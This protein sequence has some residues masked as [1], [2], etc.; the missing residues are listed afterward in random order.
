MSSRT[1]NLNTYFDYYLILILSR[2]NQVDV[3]MPGVVHLVSKHSNGTLNL[4]K[5]QFQENSKYQSLV[6]VSHLSRVCG[7]RFLL[8]SVH[9]HPILPFLLTN[10]VNELNNNSLAEESSDHECGLLETF[11]RGIIIWG[12]EPVRPL[13][14]TG[15]I[16]ELARVDSSKP[17]SFE[18]IAWFPS[19]LPSS[20]LG[21]L[22]SSP[23]TLFAS[24]D[25][26]KITI[27]QA[28]F[29]ART[30]LHDLQ[31]QQTKN[32][33]PNGHPVYNKLISTVSAT[34]S[35]TTDIPY[36]NFNIVSIQSTARPGCIIELDH[37]A[38]S[39]HS[40]GSWL[41]ADLFHVYQEGLIRSASR[42][43]KQTRANKNLPYQP[44]SSASAISEQHVFNETF[45]VVLLEKSRRT[46]RLVQQI[47]MWQVNIKS[48]LFVSETSGDD[49]ESSISASASKNRL[50]I[51][52]QRVCNQEL[53]LP[54]GVHVVS[55]ETAA[56]DLA[57]SAMFSI[58]QVP[59][60]FATG[61][62]DG[63]VRF[64]SCSQKEDTSDDE[65]AQFEF[66]EWKMS[67]LSGSQVK[68][69]A[70][71]L[72]I[73]CSYN[74][75]F[76][77]AFRKA[78]SSV[79]DTKSTNNKT[80]ADYCVNIYECES[81]GG[82][83]WR[84]EDSICLNSIVL[85]ELDSGINLDYIFGD[86]KPIKP[87]RSMH[88]F[89]NMIFGGSGGSTYVGGTTSPPHSANIAA[90][91]SSGLFTPFNAA[92]D[93]KSTPAAPIP[94]EI[95]STAAKISIKRQITTL[96][97]IK[98]HN[99]RFK[100]KA[101]NLDWGSTENGSHI[102]TIGL[103]NRI[104]VYSCVMRA[105]STSSSS[106]NDGLIEWKQ[107]RTF[108]LDSAD[109]QQ[110]LPSHVKWVREGLL[111]IGLDTEMQVY[112]QW[113]SNVVKSIKNEVVDDTMKSVSQ[114]NSRKPSASIVTRKNASVLDLNKLSKMT[115]EKKPAGSRL[116]DDL[117]SERRESVM[118]EFERNN[119]LT[120]SKQF[121][122]SSIIQAP[123]KKFDHAELLEMMQDSGLFM[124]AKFAWPVLPQY[125]PRQLLELMN[126]GK[127]NRVKAI[128]MH[129][130]RCIIDFELKN[131]SKVNT[132]KKLKRKMSVSSE[133]EMPEEQVL[134]YLE[135]DTIPPLPL[136]ALF[137]SDNDD[138]KDQEEESA[139]SQDNTENKSSFDLLSGGGDSDELKLNSTAFDDDFE[140]DED[141]KAKILEKRAAK[142]KLEFKKTL[143]AS[144]QSLQNFNS[145]VCKLLIEY[146]TCVHL[147]GLTSIDQ[148]YLV[149]LADTVANVR[150]DNINMAGN[151]ND[152]FAKKDSSSNTTNQIVDNCGLKFLLALRSY[153]YLIRT[154][155]APN[156]AEL[157][158]VGLG[159]ANFAW[160]YHS[161]CEQELLA[162][163]SPSSGENESASVLTW[164]DLRQYGVG[165][166]LK[167]TTLLKQLI[168]KVA[169][170]AFQ[171]KNDPLD[172]ALFYLAMK[173][174]GVLWGLF[175]TVK[176]VK[177]SEFFKNDFAEAKWQTA[178][179]KNAF[180]LLGKQRFE[181]AAAFF[182]LAGRLKDAVE[183]CIRSLH[184]LQLALVIVRLY[185]TDYDKLS[186]YI[187]SI[188][189]AEVLGY[190]LLPSV[191]ASGVKKSDSFGQLSAQPKPENISP[192]AFL[193]SMSYWY[194]KDYK[195]A[196]NT[197]Y[198]VEKG[199][200]TTYST[201]E[202]S[203]TTTNISQVFNFYTF[204]KN[205]PLLIR[206]QLVDN[207]TKSTKTLMPVE[208]R[209]HFIAGYYHLVNGCPL[210]SLD[211]LSKLPKYLATNNEDTSSSNF[212]EE[213]KL[214]FVDNVPKKIEK[215]ADFDWSAPTYNRFNDDEELDLKLD[216]DEDDEEE[217]KE[218]V[219]V[220]EKKNMTDDDKINKA[221][222]LV[223]Q[224][225][226][227]GGIVDTFA[228][229]IK[230]ISCLKI[231]IEEMSTLSTG[232]EVVGGQLR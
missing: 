150:C 44:Y 26:D 45:F 121:L 100:K 133:S 188:L 7:H 35:T 168:E 158:Q 5:L 141:T 212:E 65:Q 220:E 191:D 24:T 54:D 194:V 140:F 222:A 55:A 203:S 42:K 117:V 49:A 132:Q 79:D 167:N 23:S 137:A 36:D 204:L 85:P 97:T 162:A 71:P 147:Q 106:G 96:N 219:K 116:G 166:W 127:I 112:S 84:L 180:V 50:T 156:R 164:S 75:R 138:M 144:N 41:K 185:E 80:F 154:L 146:L 136:F 151:T 70:V 10:S 184:D 189:F 56:A 169:K 217:I 98:P 153:N 182:L 119:S 93:T 139:T 102:L 99:S 30:L 53:Q 15:G 120:G 196:L 64:W 86:E 157:R 224:K 67:D 43:K 12:V 108:E 148:M 208:R 29:D 199:D 109:D 52:S 110:A 51:S 227:T 88:S 87:T 209:L 115:K 103:G 205:H 142:E 231:L 25:A 173:K 206:Q 193:R 107:F 57:A 201:S 28:V 3:F 131:N 82:S 179:L 61:C 92:V 129:L 114:M 126:Y 83:E 58:N 152:M 16:Y 104:F 22:S 135:I 190:D 216:S 39:A 176:D 2:S 1:L 74:S 32:T 21:N 14:V 76:A 172:A 213:K 215:A 197:L 130:T 47:H 128:L 170:T 198:D 202:S 73:S 33:Q 77:V 4:W 218:V 177:M 60:L 149:A 123:Q 187:K 8:N 175:K 174:K 134:N 122:A 46:N 207:E 232:F 40:Q 27:Y 78:S 59:Y 34:G 171:Q 105:K 143:L 118:D 90:S 11:Q 66:V 89:K 226:D 95:P 6:Y 19:F 214:D 165:W 38:D 13:C 186:H 229:Q 195:Q 178:A 81:T 18:N 228:Q 17:N 9:S 68:C 200:L 221:P 181:H 183:V 225:D 161:E 230:F 155:P 192:D 101:I 94:I 124:Q 37:L 210:L 223:D 91:P 111:V 20:T 125:H 159:T 62:S 211:I 163:L 63:V 145:R 69:D 48:S 113:S 31:R 160:A 72:S